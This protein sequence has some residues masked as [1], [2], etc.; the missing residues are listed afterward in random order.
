[1]AA[2]VEQLE[3]DLADARR[4]LAEPDLTQAVDAAARVWFEGLQRDRRDPGRLNQATGEP[5]RWEDLPRFDRHR[6]RA[7]VLPVVTA[8]FD[9]VKDRL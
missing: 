8:A 6:Y 1:M 3:R 5:W 7:L 4:R 2:K 9:A